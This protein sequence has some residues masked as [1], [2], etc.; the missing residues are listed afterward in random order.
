MNWLL[1][2]ICFCGFMQAEDPYAAWQAGRPAEAI[3][4][5]R[6]R[7]ESTNSWQAWYDLGLCAAAAE[8]HG[9][10]S[11]ALVA[12]HRRAPW[13]SEARSALVL[14]GQRMPASSV[15]WLGPLA[16]P[17]L[18]WQALM[19]ALLAGASLGS[20]I[21]IARH[22]FI[23][24][25]LGAAASFAVLPGALAAWLDGRTPIAAIPN[26]TSLSDATGRI[27]CNLDA[28]TVV[29]L[30]HDQVWQDRY[31]VDVGDGQ[32]GYVPVADLAQY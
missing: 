5:L 26:E 21:Y 4:D 13:R 16:W 6:T 3:D 2:I 25:S 9:L 20:A 24:I 18:S 19:L 32:H 12:A 1:L 23:L 28:G 27:I 14:L 29:V 17:G 7:A 15:A 22:R 30:V 31:L 11:A 8:Q 10:A